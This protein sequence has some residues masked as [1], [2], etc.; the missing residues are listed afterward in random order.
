MSLKFTKISLCA[1]SA[2]IVAGGT[3]ILAQPPV[4][5]QLVR[6]ALKTEGV[7]LQPVSAQPVIRTVA[8]GEPRELPSTES[9]SIREDFAKFTK[10]TDT[11]PDTEA[12][13]SS[14]FKDGK[15]INIDDALMQ[16]PGWTGSDCYMAGGTCALISPSFTQAGYINTPLGDYSGHVHVK[17]RM[18]AVSTVEDDEWSLEHDANVMIVMGTGGYDYPDLAKITDLEVLSEKGRNAEVYVQLSLDRAEG[19]QQV[20]FTFNNNSSQSDS[21]MQFS[22][23]GG[24]VVDDIEID[25][26]GSYLPYPVA[27]DVSGFT[28]DGFTL[29][30]HPIRTVS[31]FEVNVTEYKYNEGDD[32][33]HKTDFEDGKKPGWLAITDGIAP[34]EVAEEV[35]RDGSKGLKMYS[36]ATVTVSSENSRLMNGLFWLGGSKLD[37]TSVLKDA[38]FY[39]DVFDGCSWS[40][41]STFYRDELNM[42]G[43]IDFVEWFALSGGFP[44]KYYSLRFRT[45]G[46]PEGVYVVLD[47]IGFN[48][49]PGGTVTEK[50]KNAK[51][52][53]NSYRVEGTDA[54]CDYY[55]TVTSIKGG[56]RRS[57]P[58]SAVTGV[59]APLAY[60]ATDI[61]RR[62]SYVASW[63]ECPRATN[64]E[65]HNFGLTDVESDKDAFVIID[66]D[67][68]GCK[69]G[70]VA[71]PSPLYN[72]RCELDEFTSMPGWEGESNISADGMMGCAESDMGS[73]LVTPYLN[74]D[75]AGSYDLSLRAYGRLGDTLVLYTSEG[76]TFY[77]P[78]EDAGDGTTG[79][80]DDTFTVPDAQFMT[81][82][83]VMSAN[84]TPFL[85]DRYCVKQSVKAPDT[86]LTWLGAGY[87]DNTVFSHKFMDFRQHEYDT[88]GYGVFA[89]KRINS[90]TELRS[91]MSNLV[92]VSFTDDVENIKAADREVEAVYSIDGMRLNCVR[93]GINIVRY[94]DGTCRKVIAR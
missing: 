80:I 91:D 33:I 68:N 39:I 42:E 79:V 34:C 86:V 22:S 84:G 12:I 27:A 10:G 49:G 40:N 90:N 93:P 63:S 44:D 15:T 14:Y 9:F 55:Y 81:Y 47:D 61:N 45:E 82:S 28:L 11:E 59:P 6:P 72:D 2:L 74:L 35:G 57:A 54:A 3:I 77:I 43:S 69:E 51:C 37:D 66:E 18:K 31:D 52:E 53:T 36:D 73:Y 20:E 64:Y 87:Y 32:I 19:W 70:T 88:Y 30:W 58:V 83:M 17:C 8:A 1:A 56:E 13:A 41:L 24:I 7:R 46:L 16:S 78:F 50:V 48:M 29:N 62:G 67:F 85:L 65:V 23:I 5:R 71:E 94:T 76:R 92:R 60:E 89:T 25:V 38:R 4:S 21:Y 75:H 26:D